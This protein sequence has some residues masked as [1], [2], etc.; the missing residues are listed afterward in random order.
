MKH[1]LKTWMVL[2]L[3]TVAGAASAQ[4]AVGTVKSVRGD[5]RIER[6]GRTL[7]ARAGDAVQQRDRIVTGA[8]S[9]AGIGFVDLSSI[10]VGAKSDVDL[11]RYSFN[12]T[13]HQGEQQVRVR[14]GSLAS[15]SGKVA[16]A[17]PEAVQFNAGTV[18]LGVRGTRFVVEVQPAG[19]ANVAYHWMAAG[20][21]I[22]T[23]VGGCVGTAA[24]SASAVRSDCLPDR[25]VLL[26]DANGQVGRIVLQ[27][28]EQTLTVSEAYAGAVQGSG[29]LQPSVQTAADAQARYAQLL[30][31]LPPQAQTFQLRFASGSATQLSQD[32]LAELARLKA[33]IAAWPVAAD[34][35]VVGHTDTVGA[36]A[37]ND[38]LSLE[39]AHTV[40][41]LLMDA[42]LPA[43]RVQAHGRGE[44]ELQV[45]TPDETPEARNRRVEVTLY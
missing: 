21:V 3:V 37:Q 27:S 25:F 34:L 40:R 31:A 10:A 23:G 7:S 19:E 14:S 24:A 26:P 39:R 36:A 8:D 42:G 6:Q 44:R 17:S 13:T 2:A 20:Q 18:T 1:T 12:G 32:S 22:R 41:K 9:S 4:D 16:K 43:E 38:K 35:S 28:G 33:T 11:T 15:I 29:P 5:V 45:P 30:S